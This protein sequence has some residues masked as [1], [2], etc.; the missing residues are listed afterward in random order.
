MI[1]TFSHDK[2]LDEEEGIHETIKS[3]VIIGKVDFIMAF[4]FNWN[5]L[6][7]I[8]LPKKLLTSLTVLL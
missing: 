3:L 1:S 6:I 5:L 4:D 2:S 8:C 7:N